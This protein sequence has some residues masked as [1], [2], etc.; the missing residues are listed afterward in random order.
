MEVRQK[1]IIHSSLTKLHLVA[2]KAYNKPLLMFSIGICKLCGIYT[3][4]VQ[5]NISCVSIL[6][7]LNMVSH[8]LWCIL[9]YKMTW[10]HSDLQR[11]YIIYI[12]FFYFFFY[13]SY[14]QQLYIAHL[15]DT[16]KRIFIIDDFNMQVYK[17]I[18]LLKLELVQCS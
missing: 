9:V 17:L 5:S 3:K 14:Q 8:R 7:S 11:I 2:W 13:T 15:C 10:S 4:A 12:F 6:V 18:K 1:F 16:Y